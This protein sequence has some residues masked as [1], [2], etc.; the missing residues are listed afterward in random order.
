MGCV[1]VGRN[2]PE[3]GKRDLLRRG[4]LSCPEA[5]NGHNA[6]LT[7]KA[8]MLSAEEDCCRD[9]KI[10]WR[11]LRRTKVYRKEY[12]PQA[13]RAGRADEGLPAY[14]LLEASVESGD[15]MGL[16]VG[17]TGLLCGC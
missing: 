1:G 5:P 6:T 9:C 12:S 11:R 16:G 15:I 7:S 4:C 13:L 14:S 17:R 8:R 2:W 10:G 3:P